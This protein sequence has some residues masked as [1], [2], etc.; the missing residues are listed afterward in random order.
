MKPISRSVKIDGV[1]K[2]AIEI[3]RNRLLVAGCLIALGFI[4]VG[5]RVI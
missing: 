3:G 2:Q 1:A 4:A 5:G